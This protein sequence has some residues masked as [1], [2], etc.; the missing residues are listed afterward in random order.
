MQDKNINNGLFLQKQQK[1]KIIRNDILL[2]AIVLVAAITAIFVI[3]VVRHTGDCVVVEIDGI[4]TGRY[5][6][7]TDRQIT[8]SSGQDNQYVNVLVIKDS[9]AFVSEADCRDKICVNHSAIS[10]ENETIICLPHKVVVRISS[11]N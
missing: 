7:S 4:E 8:I 5:S 2:I 3:N 6:L 10:K 11:E 1:K 9:K